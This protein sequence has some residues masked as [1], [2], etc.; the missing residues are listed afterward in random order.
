[1]TDRPSP[2]LDSRSNWLKSWSGHIYVA[3]EVLGRFI[4]PSITS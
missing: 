4:W 2:Q 1:M 3:S